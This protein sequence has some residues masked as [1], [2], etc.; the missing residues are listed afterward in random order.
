MARFQLGFIIFFNNPFL[1]RVIENKKIS[2]T[3][4]GIAKVFLKI[5][6]LA[7]PKSGIRVEAFTSSQ[8]AHKLPG[9]S[10]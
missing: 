5:P 10:Y 6:T 7:L 4:W 3:F 8:P 9:S 1:C 2:D